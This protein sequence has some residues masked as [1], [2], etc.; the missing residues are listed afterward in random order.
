LIQITIK[1]EIMELKEFQNPKYHTL[2]EFRFESG[3]ILKNLLVE[4][5]TI[6]TP[7]KNNKG[8]L[9]NSVV[10][11]HGWSGNFASF[12]KMSEL[13]GKGKTLDTDKFFLISI[14]TLGSPESSSPSTSKLGTKFP[15]YTIKDM[16]NFQMEFLKEKFQITHV[17]G[18]IGNSM[19]G[20]QVLEWASSYPSTVDFII[21][22]VS[23]YKV[24][25]TNYSL[26]KFMNHII[27]NDTEYNNG[28]YD[29]PLKSL[30]I[31]NESVYSFGFSEEFYRSL[32]KKEIDLSM[33]KIAEEGMELDAN[34]IIYRNNA[35]ISYDISDKIADIKAKTLIVAINQDKFFPPE[36]DGIPMC[37]LIKNSKLVRY[38]S[39]LGHVGTIE[40]SKINNELNDFLEKFH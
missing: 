33:E 1:K 20:F 24:D 13:I 37:K 31:A 10:Y 23:S 2:K 7:I 4:Y 25:G 14:T 8:E 9:I 26:Y 36:L 6:G 29:N 16:A 28:N 17:K 22:L 21:T 30:K 40:I 32:S 38:D 3:E 27:E 5:T 19:G 34:D 18:L 12:R 11:L 35:S 15:N 39:L